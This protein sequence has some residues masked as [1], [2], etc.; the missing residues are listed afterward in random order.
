MGRK[1]SREYAIAALVAT[2]NI[3]DAALQCGVSEK[4][5]HKWLNDSEFAAALQRAQADVTREAMKRVLKAVGQAVAVLEEIMKD[6][7]HPPAPRVSAAKAILENALKV[8]DLEDVQKR[9][10]ALES[11]MENEKLR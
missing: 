3:K 11:R 6:V 10:D 1:V 7:S 4:T 5:M 9:L 2:P 8:Y